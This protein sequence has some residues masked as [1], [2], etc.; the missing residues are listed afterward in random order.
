M[1]LLS[2]LMLVLLCLFIRHYSF[3]QTL[4]K[5]ADISW[6]TQ[7]E[8]QNI[9]FYNSAGVQKDLIPILK[10]KGMNSIRLR[11]WV[12][13]VDGWNNMAD[14][15]AKAIR[16]KSNGMRIMIDFHYSDTWA[17]P[18]DQLKPANWSGQNLAALKASVYNHTYS[19]LNTLKENQIT[20][21]WVQVGNETNNGMLWEEGKASVNEQLCAASQFWL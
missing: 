17:D 1:K 2:T 16:A 13:P 14:V 4:A 5:G 15:L 10:E 3:S 6:L 8:A 11:V 19:V 9:K 18:G 20:P 12:N 21:E 7:M